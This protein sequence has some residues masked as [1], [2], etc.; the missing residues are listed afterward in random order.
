MAICNLTGKK[1]IWW[2]DIK[3]FKGIK[4]IYVTRKTFKNHFKIKYLSKQ[5][6]EEKDKE[7]YDLRLGFMLMKEICSK[8]VSLLRYIPYIIDEK[9]RIQRFLSCF[10]TMFKEQIEYDNLKM[11][12]EAMR[13]ENLCYT[14]KKRKCTCLEE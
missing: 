11:L 2:K 1:N 14:K 13:K 6:Y 4:E 7:F 12:E 3:K 9:N 10:P 8:F 5:Y